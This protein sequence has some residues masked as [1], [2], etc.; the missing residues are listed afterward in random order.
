MIGDFNFRKISWPLGT[1]GKGCTT[2]EQNQAKLLINLTDELLLTQYILKPTRLNNILDLVFT[3]NDK[4]VYDYSIVPTAY[5]DH[6]I[7]SLALNHKKP[8]FAATDSKPRI[9]PKLSLLN[10]HS[11]D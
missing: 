4:L 6:N 2:S 3:N 11:V 10:F 5:S 8:P 1:I 9:V 7:I